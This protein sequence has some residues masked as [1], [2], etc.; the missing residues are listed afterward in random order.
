M[1]FFN[2]KSKFGFIRA[3]E[4]QVDYYVAQKNLIDEVEAGEEVEFEV[5]IAKRGP[6]AVNVKK[7]H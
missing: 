4:D 3:N 5:K 2:R 7:A 6:E 1:I